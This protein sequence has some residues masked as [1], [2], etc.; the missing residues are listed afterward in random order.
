MLGGTVVNITGPCFNESQKIKCRFENEVVIGTVIDKNRAICVQPFLKYEGYIRFYIAIDSGTYDW[1]GKYF[2]GKISLSSQFYSRFLFNTVR[3]DLF[4]I[5]LITYNNKMIVFILF[6]IKFVIKYLETPATA[7]E[8][9]F[10]IDKEAVHLKDP[11]EIKITW[12]AYNLTTN[13]GAGIHISLWGYRETKTT[14]EFEYIAMLDVR[15]NLRR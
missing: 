4:S 13:I 2:V 8:R 12:N 1:K 5:T 3:V 11:A 6:V 9:I 15:D 14:P 7:T 10:F